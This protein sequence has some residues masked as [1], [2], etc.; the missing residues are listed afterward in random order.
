MGR[1]FLCL[2][3]RMRVVRLRC[4]M[5]L[6]LPKTIFMCLLCRS[7]A[8]H[9]AVSRHR[10]IFE[11]VIFEVGPIKVPILTLSRGNTLNFGKRVRILGDKCLSCPLYSQLSPLP[12]PSRGENS[13]FSTATSKEKGVVVC[14]RSSG[15]VGLR[16]GQG[17]P[18]PSA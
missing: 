11:A 1:A 10:N 12:L 8:S 14:N 17:A 15:C 4:E 6:I 9:S 5:R 7:D 13:L 16:F 3:M 2:K 18:S